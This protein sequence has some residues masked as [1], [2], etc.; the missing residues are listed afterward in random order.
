[1]LNVTELLFSLLRVARR[2]LGRIHGTMLDA[3][4]RVGALCMLIISASLIL[5]G[6]STVP[7]GKNPIEMGPSTDPTYYLHRTPSQ[8]PT[9]APAGLRMNTT[10]PPSGQTETT[11]QFNKGTNYYWY[12][13]LLT[14]GCAAGERG[15]SM[16]GLTPR[17]HYPLWMSALT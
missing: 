4:R 9:P 2:C 5:G 12:S 6:L 13:D 17:L 7:S 3:P 10:A 8:T 11:L 14:P 1:M 16:S 15:H